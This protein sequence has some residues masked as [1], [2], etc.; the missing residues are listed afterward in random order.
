MIH[1]FDSADK[2]RI[3]GHIK[4]IVHI[5]NLDGIIDEEEQKCIEKIGKRF[6]ITGEEI[7]HL[8]KD[9]SAYDYHAPIDLE[10]RFEFLYDLMMMIL[11]D[12]VIDDNERKIFRYTA[13]NMHFDHKKVDEIMNFFIEEINSKADTEKMFKDFKT[14]LLS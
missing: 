7:Q 2:K 13:I 6:G 8:I 3:K 12:Q 1:L 11:A 9:D 10:E 14:L 5:A 4:N